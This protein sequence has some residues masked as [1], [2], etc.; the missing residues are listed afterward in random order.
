MRP[1]T[2]ALAVAYGSAPGTARCA[3]WEETLTMAP[4]RPAARKRL[5]ATAHPATTRPRLSA[6]SSSTSR[7][8]NGVQRRIPEDR[9]V[10]HPAGQ[11]AHPLGGIG[12]LARD[13]PPDPLAAAGHDV[14]LHRPILAPVRSGRGDVRGRGAD[15]ALPARDQRAPVAGTRHWQVRDKLF[16]WERP[17]RG[18]D[19]RR[20][21]RRRARRADPRR[22]RRASRGQGIAAGLRPDYCFTTP[23]FD[24]YPAVLVQ[25]DRIGREDLEELVVEAW[26]A[27]APKRLADA[28]V[29]GR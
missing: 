11:L 5:T 3:W 19:L 6:I 21:R 10:V 28:Y 12:R 20:A 24:G 4:G 22:A 2:A 25:L 9:R 17:L 18:S 26:L 8:G 27:R 29:A 7:A 15:R 14:G 23:H 13:R 16:V 1:S